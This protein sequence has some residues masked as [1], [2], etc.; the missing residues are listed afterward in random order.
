MLDDGGFRPGPRVIFVVLAL[1][2]LVA[3]GFADREAAS[4]AARQPVTL[5]LL[6]LGVLGAVSAAWTVGS[7]GNAVRWGLVTIGYGAILVSGWVVSRRRFGRAGIATLVVLVGF[8]SAV[9]GLCG[10]T[11]FAEPFADHTSGFWRPGGTLE[12]SAAL[13]LLEVAALPIL[14]TAMAHRNRLLAAG[15]AFLAAV[16]AVVLALGHSRLECAFAT[17][18][19]A[20][21]VTLP[22]RTVHASRA[23]ATSAVAVLALAAV[24]AYLIAGAR[25]AVSAHHHQAARLGGIAVVCLAAGV[26]WAIGRAPSLRRP[27][28]LGAIAAVLAIAAAVVA[29]TAVAGDTSHYFNTQYGGFFHGRLSLWGTALSTARHDFVLGHG[30]DSF[31]PATEFTQTGGAIRFAHD[32]PLELA[33]ELGIVGFALALAL[34]ASTLTAIW[35]SRRRP[36][37]WLFGVAALTFPLANLLDWEWHLAGSGAVWAL[38]LG[39]LIARPAPAS[40]NV[41]ASGPP[42][43]QSRQARIAAAKRSS[44]PGARSRYRLGSIASSSISTGSPEGPGTRSTRE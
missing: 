29:I 23:T 21:A 24:G 39:A 8:I 9:I 19:C 22:R 28:R 15:A 11:A 31:L 10:A 13:S 5:V 16:A 36:D 25:V 12:Y 37:A 4:R 40:S 34:Y 14:L 26:V 43:E 18:V 3:A 33:V 2:S 27:A 17:L 32:L 35:R 7:V 6:A 41:V 42:H 38:A 44:A 30:A 1:A 20:A